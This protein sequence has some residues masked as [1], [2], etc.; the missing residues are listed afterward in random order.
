[1]IL[2]GS[3][4]HVRRARHGGYKRCMVKKKSFSDLKRMRTKR[5][6]WIKWLSLIHSSDFSQKHKNFLIVTLSESYCNIPVHKRSKI[7]VKAEVTIL[8]SGRY[9]DRYLI[10]GWDQLIWSWSVIVQTLLLWRMYVEI[11]GCFK[12]STSHLRQFLI[13][14]LNNLHHTEPK[15]FV[16][17]PC[18][19][20]PI[21]PP[22]IQELPQ[23]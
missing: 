17:D 4:F 14:S 1:M 7:H 3:Q 22:Q 10:W 9:V 13:C 20:I 5:M 19:I 16:K 11:W 12:V 8:L 23:W 6:R 15:S 21:S 18:M 2:V